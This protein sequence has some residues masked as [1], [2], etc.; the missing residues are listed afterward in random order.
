MGPRACDGVSRHGRRRCLGR[1][2]GGARVGVFDGR[3]GNG[4]LGGRL[5]LEVLGRCLSGA[6]TP[7]EETRHGPVADAALE[8]EDVSTGHRAR[9][10]GHHLAHLARAMQQLALGRRRLHGVGAS[11]GR[12]GRQLLLVARPVAHCPASH[13]AAVG[14]VGGARLR[15]AQ[16]S[17][18]NPHSST[19]AA[20][21]KAPSA[22]ERMPAG[23]R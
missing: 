16:A 2:L 18:V 8:G 17:T 1:P 10:V 11:A 13:L 20:S 21:G 5:V 22:P 4:A 6:V 19:S 3:C 9:V 14:R 7:D 12:V 15:T 23:D